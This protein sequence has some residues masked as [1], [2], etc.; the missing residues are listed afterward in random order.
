VCVS[1]RSDFLT[2]VARLI[3]QL[4]I[5]SITLINYACISNNKHCL[6]LLR[7]CTIRCKLFHYLSIS[8]L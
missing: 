5:L 8:L 4:Y 2:L 7:V 1:C 3:V 6:N